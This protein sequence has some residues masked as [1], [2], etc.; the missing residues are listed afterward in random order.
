[1]DSPEAASLNRPKARAFEMDLVRGFAIFMMV[2][3]HTAYDLRFIF[4]YNVF[5]FIDAGCTW[6]WAFLHPFFIFLFVGI[7]GICCQFSRNNYKRALKLALVAAA[8]SAATITVD[9][10]YKLD[11]SIY[12]NILHLLAVSTFLF[13]VFDHAEQKKTGKRESRGGD[14]ILFSI[15]M[16]SFWLFHAISFYHYK[17]KCGWVA[18]LGIEPHPDFSLHAGDEIGLIPWVG[19]FVLGVL[20][21]RHI[22]K[23]KE[24]LFP[25]APK[26][27]RAVSKPFEWIGRNSLLVYILHQPVILGILYGLKYLGVLK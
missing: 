17:I 20:I 12:F 22:Y 7:S 26:A 3:H 10:F 27:V 2:L 16:L 18:I 4:E 5:P 13:A 15:V 25:N 1:M 9:H 14:A 6:F 23:K 11:C 19:V 24:T 21:G 8:F